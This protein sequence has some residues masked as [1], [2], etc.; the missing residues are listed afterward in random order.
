MYTFFDKDPRDR[1]P[2]PEKRR[3]NRLLYAIVGGLVVVSVGCFAWAAWGHEALPT[4]AKPNGWS[5]PWACCSGMDCREVGNSETPHAKLRIFERP[6]GYVISSTGEVV[7]Y[8]DT[9]VK[10]SPDGE[11]HLCTVGGADNSR[12]ICLFRPPRGF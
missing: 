12:V 11:F 7:G 2:Y 1:D 9:R 4:A 8:T 6:E 5:Y 10:D 3:D